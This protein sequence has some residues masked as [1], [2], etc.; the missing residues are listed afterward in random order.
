MTKAELRAQMRAMRM[1]LLPEERARLGARIAEYAWP[2]LEG[3]QSVLLYAD[4]F[5]EVPTG[6]LA[7]RLLAQGTALYYPRTLGGGRMRAVR[8]YELSQLHPGRMGILEP[9]GNEDAEE[10]QVV[11]LPGIAF[12]RC[13][14]R[15]G[16]GAGYYD[17]FLAG[18][19]GRFV[20]L[21]YSFQIVDGLP[22]EA[23]DVL[24]HAIVT[25]EG[26]CDCIKGELK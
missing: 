5:G 3:A 9:E 15:L 24:V 19:R 17:R 6:A 4:S 23:H 13:G 21:A 1:A 12:S 18:K 22:G 10:M 20:A 7:R 11:L 14:V 26:V 16:F 25:E 8:V 2:L